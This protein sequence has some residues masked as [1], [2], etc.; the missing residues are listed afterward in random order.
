MAVSTQ[1]LP[2]G[3]LTSTRGRLSMRSLC[4]ATEQLCTQQ[5]PSTSRM[6]YR[7]GANIDFSSFGTTALQTLYS[8]Q[9]TETLQRRL[10]VKIQATFQVGM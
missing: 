5:A 1:R 2:L 8:A 6:P 10:A 9:G 3:V 7:S 4:A